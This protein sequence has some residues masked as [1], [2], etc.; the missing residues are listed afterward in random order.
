MRQSHEPLDSIIY[1]GKQRVFD[2]PEYLYENK[3]CNF[4]SAPTMYVTCEAATSV[5]NG[6]THID[7]R[8]K[9][10]KMLKFLVKHEIQSPTLMSLR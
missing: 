10:C 1:F 6:V 8:K 4:S 9:L 3:G 7:H 2:Q 5:S